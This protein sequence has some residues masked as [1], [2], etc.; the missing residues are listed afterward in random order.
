MGFGDYINFPHFC[1]IRIASTYKEWTDEQLVTTYRKDGDQQ[2]LAELFLRYHELL[3]GTCMKYLKDQEQAKDAVINIYEELVVKLQKHE[4]DNFR[5]WVHMVTKNHCLMQLRKTK[6]EF[7]TEIT[8]NDVYS[9]GTTHLEDVLTKENELNRLEHCIEGL[10][11]GQRSVIRMFYLEER[12]YKEIAELT[13]NDWNKI[14]SLVQ[15][16]RRNLKLCMERN[17]A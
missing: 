6:K 11:D 10:V 1:F 5:G 13:G 17:G 8:E 7:A 3:Y 4:V 2:L 12:S 14:R 16:G 9:E 15:N